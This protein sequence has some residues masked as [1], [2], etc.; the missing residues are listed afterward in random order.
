MPKAQQ[1]GGIW[2]KQ[3]LDLLDKEIPRLRKKIKNVQ[4]CFTTDPFMYG[5]GEVSEMTLAAIRKLNDSNIPCTILSKGI[6]PVSLAQYSSSNTYGITLVSLDNEFRNKYEP[7]TATYHERINS[8][9]F[10]HNLGCQTWVSIEPYPTP[11]IVE[12]ELS[13]VLDA[14]SFVDKIVFGR[15]NY[16]KAVTSYTDHK[17]YYHDMAVSV[18]QYCSERNIEYYIKKGTL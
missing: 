7:G 1:F 13:D 9:R 15:T 11:N 12:Q 6:L 17:K 14:V 10:L 18:I 2:T 8:L 4:L 16:S 5:Y 3:K